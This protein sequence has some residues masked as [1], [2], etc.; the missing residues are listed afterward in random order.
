MPSPSPNILWSNNLQSLI[1]DKPSGDAKVI[2]VGL[3]NQTHL[4][5]RQVDFPLTDN[6]QSTRNDP[7]GNFKNDVELP[8]TTKSV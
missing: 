5:V 8:S 2:E 1:S 3:I 4:E 7:I 6:I